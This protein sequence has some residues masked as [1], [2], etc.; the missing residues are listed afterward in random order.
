MT[1][2]QN[3]VITNLAQ[4]PGKGALR[5]QLAGGSRV[6]AKRY[7]TIDFGTHYPV[8]GADISSIFDEFNDV[9]QITC[10]PVSGRFVIPDYTNQ[11]LLLYTAIGTAASDDTDQSSITDIRLTVEGYP[12]SV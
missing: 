7:Y 11:T 5:P 9:F 10:S 6:T 1:A 2:A 3:S 12:K 4:G 8:G